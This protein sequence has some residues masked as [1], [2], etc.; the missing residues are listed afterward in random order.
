MPHFIRIFLKRNNIN[1]LN[2][3]RLLNDMR[4][5]V[6]LFFVIRLYGITQP[7]LEIAHNWRQ[8]T[9]TMVARNFYETDNNIFQ[10]RIDIGGHLSGITGME[11]PVLNYLI[12]L[13]SLFF[14]YDHWYGRLINLFVSSIGI[15]SYYDI[16][17]RLRNHK[18]ALYAGLILL[19]SLWFTYSRKIMP[20][21]FSV[22]LVIIGT[23]QAVIYLLKGANNWRLALFFLLTAFGLL[24]KLP[25]IAALAL[26]PFLLL[27]K[28]YALRLRIHV[29]VAGVFAVIPACFWYFWYIPYLNETFHLVHFFIGKPMSVAVQEILGQWQPAFAQFYET[30]MRYSGFVVFVAGLIISVRKDKHM[31]LF[32]LVSLVMFLILILKAG[33]NFVRHSYYMIPFIPVMAVFAALALVNIQSEKLAVVL[34]ALIMIEGILN[35]QHDFRLKEKDLPLLNLEAVLADYSAADELVAINSGEYPTPMYFAHRKGWVC[36]NQMLSDTNYVNGLSDNGLKTIIILKRSFGTDLLLPYA[37]VYNDAD[38]RIYK[39]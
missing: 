5:W 27:Q 37:E 17:R 19:S 28:E 36:S 8:T 6:F 38:F 35:Q 20:D 25:A 16:V 7:P 34:L 9:V 22:A 11:F 24:S 23:Q 21:T 18:L 13:W 14:G 33:D 2:S 31:S 12:Y 32:G 29:G 15:I 3:C 26:L 4:F 39:P 30:A 1:G 10:P